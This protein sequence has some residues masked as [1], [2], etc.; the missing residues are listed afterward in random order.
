M[1]RIL[2]FLCSLLTLLF[3][4]MQTQ[5]DQV[6]KAGDALLTEGSQITS[7]NTQDGFP[8]S[9]L[10]RPES[11]GYGTNQIIWHTAWTPAA[12]AGTETYLQVTFG[13]PVQH[14]IFTMI[15]SMWQQTYDT[16]TEM[17]ILA[18]NDAS[19]EWT[20]ITHLEN[21][22]ND[23]TSFRPDKYTSPH[24]DL[25]AEYT[26]VRFLVKKTMNYGETYRQDGNGNYYVSLGRFQVYEAYLGEADPVVPTWRKDVALLTEDSQITSNNSQDGF[27]PSNLL[28]PESEGYGTG[29]IIWHTSWGT[30]PVPPAGTDA[31]LQVQFAEPQQHI[32]FTMIGSMWAGTCD[33]PTEVIVQASNEPNGEWTEITH[34]EE[35]SS[36]FTSFSP[37]RYESPHIDLGAKYTYVRFV[38]KKTMNYGVANRKDSNGNYY[39]SLGR[40]QVYSAV[41]AGDEPIDPKDNINLLFIG[42]S[43]TY[44][45]TTP[46]PAAQ[47][48]PIVCRSLVAEATGVNTN[49]YNG[50]H[51]GITTF[52]FLPGRSDFTMVVNS[53]R[54]FFKQ[55]GGLTYFSIMLGTNDSAC[56]GTEGAPVSPATYAANIRKIIDGLIEAIPTCKIVLNYP[57][58]YSPSTYNG[59]RYQQEGLDRLHS[60]YP[61]LDT[62]VNEYDQVYAG[63]R[64][65]WEYFEDNRVLFTTENGND[66]KFYLHPNVNG[67]KRLAE[68]WARSL[69]DLIEADGVEIKNP[70]PAWPVFTPSNDKKYKVSTPRGKYGTKDGKVTN[71]VLTSI[72]ATEGEFA[73]ITYNGLIYP[74]SVAD[75]S[76]MFR[77]PL[78][79][80]EDW[81]N[82]I[83][84]NKVIEPIKVNYTGINASYPYCLTSG[85]YIA[86]TANITQ[87]GVCLN[88]Y[89]T[90][91]DGNSTAI[92]ESGDFD[93]TEALAVLENYFGNQVEVLYRVV[94]S[95]GNPLDSLTFG[96]VAGD[97][98]TDLPP[99]LNPKAYT[100]YTI[101]EPVTLQKEGDNI[102]TIVATW[103]LPFE[104]SP[105]RDN[106]HWY[107]L[108]LRE[109]CDYV[110]TKNAYKCNPNATQDD[111]ESNA[112]QW[113]FD[114][115]P[116][117][118]IVVFCRANPTMSLTRVGSKAYLRT[119]TFKWEIIES[120]KG[121]LLATDDKT[122][123]YINEYGG[124]GGYL[125]FWNGIDDVGSIFTVCEVGQPTVK[126]IK[127]PTGGAV[128][129]LKSDDDKA[130][131]RAILVI[132]GGGYGFIAGP[133]EGSD[134]A[135]MFNDLGYT[136]GVLNYTVPPARPDQPLSQAR[137]AMS[138]LRSHSD[139]YNVG[140]GI[141]GVIGFSA[142][143]H[144]A[145]TVATH[146]SGGEAPAFQI[147]FYPVI[148]MEASYTHSGSRQNLIGD[149]PA[150][151]LIDL[152][153]NE[154]QVTS[155]TPPAYI[156]WAD[157][158][159]TVPPANS[160]NYAAALTD[161]GVAVRTR[162]Y[163]SGGHGYGYG[164]ASNWEY[165]SD[166][167][168][169]LTQWLLGLKDDLTG[170]EN[171]ELRTENN[172]QV[173]DLQGRRVNSQS[174]M[175]NGQ[176]PKGVYIVNGQ[177]VLK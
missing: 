74:Y 113:A 157:N 168:A 11:E 5:A 142:G 134:W 24:I 170:I 85:E 140:T 2:P 46:S 54:T 6:W 139:E 95:E 12:P 146:T 119:G 55:N 76:F 92:V 78:S 44:G 61:L 3:V 58:W 62:I 166:M 49:V 171:R 155:T 48:P 126:N 98:V 13:K 122:Y 66:G 42:N 91:D 27:P 14:I 94:D 174:S 121:F 106:A 159:G 88:T 67:A 160:I 114:G 52:G 128:K 31:Y 138:Y 162:N 69:L 99:T 131:G 45:A 9:N 156:C 120:P 79:Y 177:K 47:A 16:P 53:A 115:N 150:L 7:N 80:Q 144:L 50:G 23:Y 65:V 112:Y 110:T 15:G 147:L 81:S 165:H 109:G 26:Y 56:S 82:I 25:G 41:E 111:L 129:I 158:D 21:M 96:G 154:K 60:Y 127:L 161:A 107:N 4:S 73:F 20:E 90:G 89:A 36:E 22:E 32:I 163:P 175:L 63:E 64:G 152:Y 77:D 34:L 153:S 176:L 35:M 130:N 145:S 149:N 29:E 86:N 10:L 30:P 39:V 103:Q 132:P 124:E 51:S 117:D 143:G 93:P 118:G 133:N 59:A 70:L 33:T 104:L 72:G 18:T 123:P 101:P 40:F 164:V 173:Y 84:S 167:V 68:I 71:T 38:V 169:D 137:A 17:V 57:I 105:D 97:E 1:K 108:A 75:K 83:L 151:E 87:T 102:V 43:I 136:V 116:Y 125:G 37:D 141:I 100:T 135:P 19:G 28:R 148:T 8:P 172:S